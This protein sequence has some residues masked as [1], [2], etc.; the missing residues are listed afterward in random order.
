MTDFREKA[1]IFNVFFTNQCS[2]IKNTSMLPTNCESLIDKSLSN[3]IFT[4]NDI[5]KIIRLEQSSR[6]DM[7]L[8]GMLKLCRQSICKPL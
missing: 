2:L 4:D 5:G 1:E 8:I 6:H 7:I 3:I